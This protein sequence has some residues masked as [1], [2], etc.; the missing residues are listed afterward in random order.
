MMGGTFLLSSRPPP[1]VNL[2]GRR[3]ASEAA[4]LRERS[5]SNQ[6]QHALLD[7][8]AHLAIHL[9]GFADRI[10]NVPYFHLS[11]AAAP[12]DR[13]PT[14]SRSDRS[15]L[16]RAPSP[17]DSNRPDRCFSPASRDASAAQ[18]PAPE[19]SPAL[20]ASNTSDPCA[21]ANPSAIGLRQALPIHKNNTRVLATCF[22][23]TGA[24]HGPQFRLR[25]FSQEHQVNTGVVREFRM[26]RG[27]QMPA[28]LHQHWIA[29]ITSQ[30][31]ARPR[32][33]RRMIGARINTASN[34]PSSPC[35]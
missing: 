26:K 15:H 5:R 29:L 14:Y 20:C 16:P 9:F 35:G 17:W 6:L 13:S 31:L 1:S 22:Q 18:R 3:Q 4:G 34:S 19:P 27:R 28:L 33:T 10:A 12:A 24:T 23:S 11:A 21:R 7:L 8:V 30:H 32:P 25:Y 2:R